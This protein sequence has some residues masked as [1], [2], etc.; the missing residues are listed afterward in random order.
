MPIAVMERIS[1][2][3]GQLVR[4][5]KLV[6]AMGTETPPSGVLAGLYKANPYH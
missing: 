5:G 1:V 4:T 2:D 6:A 3:Q